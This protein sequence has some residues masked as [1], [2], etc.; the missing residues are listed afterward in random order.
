M[1]RPFLALFPQSNCTGQ[2]SP[3]I[4]A[5]MVD[6]LLL[7]CVVDL[8]LLVCMVDLLLLVCMV[9][10]LLLAGTDSKMLRFL[11]GEDGFSRSYSN[12]QLSF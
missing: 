8:L 3:I 2:R 11:S 7:V 12:M 10:Q 9:D 4:L 6:L 5:C 1:E